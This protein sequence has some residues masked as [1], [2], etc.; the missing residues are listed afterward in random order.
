[1]YYVIFLR[2]TDE[3]RF[4]SNEI[5]FQEMFE[6][7]QRIPIKFIYNILNYSFSFNTC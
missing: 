6:I 3:F 2:C 4:V 5:E 7:E 1:M